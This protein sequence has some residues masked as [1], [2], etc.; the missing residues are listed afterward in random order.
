VPATTYRCCA[1]SDTPSGR[2]FPN[3]L[4]NE[5]GVVIVDEALVIVINA[6]LNGT[7]VRG[8]FAGGASMQGDEEASGG[9]V[10][11]LQPAKIRTVRGV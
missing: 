1:I 11:Y 6:I 7:V 9:Q 2:R 5:F 3:L 4:R 10:P 8:A